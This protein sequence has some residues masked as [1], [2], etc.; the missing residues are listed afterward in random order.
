MILKLNQRSEKELIATAERYMDALMQA[1]TEKDYKSHIQHFSKRLKQLLDEHRFDSVVA[2]Y[3]QEKGYFKDRIFI[4]SFMREHSFAVVWR[5]TFTQAVGD[6][7]AEIV[8]IE[9]DGQLVVDHVM[10]F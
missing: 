1:S 5:Q 7:V 3:Q 8:L 4:A 2:Q 9:E 10:V 6:Y